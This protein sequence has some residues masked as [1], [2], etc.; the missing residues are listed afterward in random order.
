MTS[1]HFPIFRVALGLLLIGSMF[2]GPVWLTALIAVIGVVRF[3]YYWEFL[4]AAVSIEVLYG[5]SGLRT[6]SAY[7]P[8][9]ALVLFGA[10][11]ASRT[12]IREEL[13]RL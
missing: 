10:V 4:I 7:L 2:L 1:T 11:E 5:G 3:P 12:Y 8:I 9:Y 13:L 6:W